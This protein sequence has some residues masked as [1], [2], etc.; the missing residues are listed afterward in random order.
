MS[1][2]VLCQASH[3]SIAPRVR[4]AQESGLRGR[5][6]SDQNAL[7]R[8]LPHR[9]EA[10]GRGGSLG[11]GKTKV[12]RDGLVAK[13][14]TSRRSNSGGSSVVDENKPIGPSS[15]SAPKPATPGGPLA[16]K[17]SLTG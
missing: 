2:S 4:G 12:G 14:R 6:R 7:T 17:P 3:P 16:P 8:T 9:L 5:A 10:R 1:S 13:A 11:L 15:S